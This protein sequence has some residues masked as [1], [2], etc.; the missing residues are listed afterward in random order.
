EKL[1]AKK[2]NQAVADREEQKKNEVLP[3]FVP[4]VTH[5]HRMLIVVQQIRMKATRETQDLKEELQKKEQIRQA[6]KKREEK[7]ADLEAKRKIKE[8]IEADKRERQRKA[9]EAKALREGR[10]LPSQPGSSS[11]SAPAVA[12]A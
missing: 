4:L 5:G 9:E 8:Q 6:A 7:A 11:S 2:A 12:A 3:P 1:K 10:S